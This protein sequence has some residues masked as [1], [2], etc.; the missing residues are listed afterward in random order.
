MTANNRNLE[1]LIGIDISEEIAKQCFTE[2]QR[3]ILEYQQGTIKVTIAHQL[4]RLYGNHL[5]TWNKDTTLVYFAA[6]VEEY[7]YLIEDLG[8]KQELI[9]T[10]KNP[11]NMKQIT[12]S[13][14][15]TATATG[16]TNETTSTAVGYNS[17]QTYNEIE[18]K[19]V[20]RTLNSEPTN[21]IKEADLT[22]DTD[23]IRLIHVAQGLLPHKQEPT[24]QQTFKRVIDKL[25]IQLNDG[26][27]PI[28]TEEE[29]KAYDEIKYADIKYHNTSLNKSGGLSRNKSR[30]ES[31]NSNTSTSA[32]NNQSLACG[33]SNTTATTGIKSDATLK[34]LKIEIPQLRARFWN[35]FKEL[36]SNIDC[37]YYL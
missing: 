10:I 9:R 12:T 35:K 30:S 13:T 24:A 26:L 29:T 21:L 31:A 8:N 34:A 28:W 2:E 3:T 1:H 4:N 6:L 23:N 18:S 32:T 17:A 36:F 16:A 37:R 5:L 14:T 15:E 25:N 20:N 22:D 19:S 33:G 11:E 7:S 27:T